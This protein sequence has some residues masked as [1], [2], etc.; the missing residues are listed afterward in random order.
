[1]P[2]K[3][4][5]IILPKKIKNDQK[6]KSS[7]GSCQY[8]VDDDSSSN[9]DLAEVGKLSAKKSTW[10]NTRQYSEQL[11]AFLRWWAVVFLLQVNKISGKHV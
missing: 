4:V 10:P 8:K 11:N 5:F 6:L 3:A 2:F 1:M 9:H 7:E